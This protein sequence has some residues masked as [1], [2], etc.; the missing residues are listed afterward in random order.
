MFFMI[1]SFDIE[2]MLLDGKVYRN[3]R[4]CYAHQRSQKNYPFKKRK[5]FNQ[6]PFA[7][8]DR[9]CNCENIVSSPDNREDGGNCNAGLMLIAVCFRILYALFIYT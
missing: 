3:G 2:L 8:S 6:K 1:Y 5:F 7:T 4:P 9:D